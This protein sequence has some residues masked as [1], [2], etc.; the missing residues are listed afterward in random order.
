VVTRRCTRLGRRRRCAVGWPNGELLTGSFALGNGTLIASADRKYIVGI[1]NS[2]ES[3]KIVNFANNTQ[4]GA[5]GDCPHCG[6]RSLFNPVVQ[7]YVETQTGNFQSIAQTAQCVS[8]KNF[9]LVTATKHAGQ[10]ATEFSLRAVYPIDKPKDTVDGAVPKAIADDF[11]EAMR[12]QFILAYK[13]TVTMCRR[14][15]QAAVLEKMASPDRSLIHQIDELAEKG[16]ITNPLKDMAH[17]IRLTG[18]VGA[19]PDED[20]LKN[21]TDEDA[22]DILQFTK[23][24]FHHVYVMP[25]KLKSRKS[26]PATAGP[27]A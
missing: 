11:A 8:C 1:Y 7:G 16:V 6:V 13:A 25:A 19:H 18:N 22:E 23:E 9:L 27:K 4:V 24:F 10:G 3:M 2:G 14:A 21:V 5:S 26:P 20:G 12:C 15:L 17:V